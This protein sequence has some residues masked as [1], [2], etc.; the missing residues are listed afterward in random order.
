MHAADVMKYCLELPETERHSLTGQGTSFSFTINSEPFA[1]F[2]TGA[3]IQWQFS[4]RVSDELFVIMH[5]PPMVRQAA[6]PNDNW[7]TINRVENFDD[8]YLKELIRWSYRKA[9]V[10]QL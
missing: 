4:L 1:Y 8:S 3:P 7:I 10:W 5:N 2:E 9:Q 6:K